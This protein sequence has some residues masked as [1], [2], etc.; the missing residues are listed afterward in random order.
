MDPLITGGVAGIIGQGINAISTIGQN[1][2][3]RHFTREMY[4]LQRENALADWQRQTAYNSPIEQMK[5]LKEAGLN[6]NLV[7]KNGATNEAAPIRSTDTPNWK[8]EAPQVDTSFVTPSIMAHYDVEQKKAGTD[9]LR[10]QTENLAIEKNLKAAEILRT[11]AD[12]NVKNLD[13]AGKEIYNKQLASLMP[14][15]IEAQSLQNKKT[16]SEIGNINA[17]TRRVGEETRKIG[18]EILNIEGMTQYMKGKGQ[19]EA[20]ELLEHIRMNDF[21]I[22]KGIEELA[23]TKA[24]TAKTEEEKKNVEQLRNVILNDARLKNIQVE[25]DKQ[26]LRYGKANIAAP[27]SGNWIEVMERMFFNAAEIWRETR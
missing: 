22:K 18:T 21:N 13:A 9:Q 24:R 6:P 27:G 15:T 26:K 20:R 5:R 10:Q 19:R 7:Y 1:K 14:L 11:I 23:E 16:L 4:N 8:G 17:T 2:K 12:T 3:N 25:L